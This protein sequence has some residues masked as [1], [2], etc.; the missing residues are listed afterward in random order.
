MFD[1]NRLRRIPPHSKEAE[2][3]LVKCLIKSSYLM[4]TLRVSQDMFYHP[5]L[6]AIFVSIKEMVENNQLVDEITLGETLKIK[7]YYDR[8]DFDSF[9]AL[10]ILTDIKNIEGYENIIIDNYEFRRVIK[11]TNDISTDAYSHDKENMYAN[12]HELLNSNNVKGE[13]VS[14]NDV[15]EDFG[16]TL[17]Q[18]MKNPGSMLSYFGIKPLDDIVSGLEGDELVFVGS[19]PSMGKTAVSLNIVSS[20]LEELSRKEKSDNEKPDIVVYFSIETSKLKIMQ[21]LFALETGI[22]LESIKKGSLTA[23]EKELI[24]EKNPIIKEKM[25]YLFINDDAVQNSDTMK[26]HL[27]KLSNDYNIALVVVDYLQLTSCIEKGESDKQRVAN[28]SR[29]LKIITKD[30]STPVICLSQLSRN[31]EFRDNKRPILSDLRE[32]G[33][34]EQDGDIIVFLYNDSYYNKSKKPSQKETL[35]I[36]VRKNRDGSLGTAYT[37]FDKAKMKVA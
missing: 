9:K 13:M 16:R 18:K 26:Q 22:N 25:K 37:T 36:I 28:N 32:A 24:R 14:G 12:I 20:Y 31:C 19:R 23:E 5:D 34:I 8:V 11:L 7:D 30:F 29:G 1:D 10:N 21:R 27:H 3:S 35:E 4:N 6:K 17:N 2:Q 33:E 15:F